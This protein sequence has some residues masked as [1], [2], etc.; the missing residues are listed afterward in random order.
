EH[1]SRVNQR[2]DSG[3][4][5]DDV[6]HQ[7]EAGLHPWPH[8]T[9]EKTA[10]NMGVLRQR[11]CAGQHKQRAV[12]HV[13]EIEYPCRGRVQD[14]A[15]E[16]FDTHDG[17]QRDDQPSC[18]LADPRADAVNRVQDALNAHPLPPLSEREIENNKAPSG[19]PAEWCFAS[20]SVPV[21]SAFS[22][23]VRSSG[24]TPSF[25]SQRYPA[26]TAWPAWQMRAAIR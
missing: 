12:K 5:K 18:G 9:V 1:V 16:D 6:Q 8:R 21:R 10:A 11:V 26:P 3:D 2:G 13:I 25:G 22:R 24:R 17:H 23:S 4:E 7:V 15:L 14:V 19:R 20:F